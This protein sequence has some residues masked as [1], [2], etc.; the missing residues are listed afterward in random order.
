MLALRSAQRNRAIWIAALG[1]AFAMLLASLLFA[2]AAQARYAPGAKARADHSASKAK[3]AFCRRCGNRRPPKSKPAPAPVPAPT[4]APAPEPDTTPQPQPETAPAPDP[5]PTQSQPDPE[6]QPAEPAAEP[7]PPAPANSIYL[8]ATI[9]GAVYDEE[10]PPWNLRPWE[11]FESHTDHEVAI[12]QVHQSW[13][14][15]DPDVL[16][17]IQAR[18]AIPMLITEYNT[19]SAVAN[20]SQDAK[21]RAMN[22]ALVAYGG[23][24]LFRWNWE[25]NGDWYPWAGA[26]QAKEW[27]AAYRHLHDVM[28]APNVSWIWNPNIY[29]PNVAPG[30]G[31]PVDPTP[32]W[33]GAAYVDWMGADGYSFNGESFT[34]VFDPI[35]ALFQQLA[36]EKPIILPEWAA[37]N[38]RGKK[39]SFI[40]EAFRLT[41]TRYPAIKA[42]L[43]YNDVLG[44][45][46]DWPLEELPAAEAAYRQGAADPYF[47][48]RPN[49][50]G[51]LSVPGA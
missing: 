12:L 44:G 30:P 27:V 6:A 47:S 48:A 3:R 46:W 18:G 39:V 1:A 13:G 20:G 29:Y 23:P 45:D 22:Q 42:M 4:P 50:S 8:G 11:T 28:T 35:Y 33:P 49:L 40:E 41:P 36:P 25:M 15:I 10:N 17:R 24:V 5:E 2:G 32:W 34:T 21:I 51:K 19:L 7:Q 14:S 31:V 38:N 43:Y 16:R 37:S 26:G 9:G